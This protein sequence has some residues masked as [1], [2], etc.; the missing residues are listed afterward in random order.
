MSIKVQRILLI[1]LLVI[2]YVIQLVVTAG[3]MINEKEEKQRIAETYVR[4]QAVVVEA[5]EVKEATGRGATGWSQHCVIKY[6]TS[7]GSVKETVYVADYNTEYAPLES[8]E[9]I[10]VLVS[11]IGQG[12]KSASIES[13][14]YSLMFI[15]FAILGALIYGG[16]IA[17]YIAE[18]KKKCR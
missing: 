5:G 7:N 3:F 18:Y 1:V 4:T 8:G 16:L 12:V 10:E 15:F 9:K 14:S 6:K 17:K 13:P 11:S 2:I